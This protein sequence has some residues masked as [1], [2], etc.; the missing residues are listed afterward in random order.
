MTITGQRYDGYLLP[1][2][3]E[4]QF[5]DECPFAV[6]VDGDHRDVPIV[7]ES[8]E[9]MIAYV[10]TANLT[11]RSKGRGGTVFWN[12]SMTAA[13]YLDRLHPLERAPTRYATAFECLVTNV[14]THWILPSDIFQLRGFGVVDDAGVPLPK[15]TARWIEWRRREDAPLVAAG[16]HPAPAPVIQA[17]LAAKRDH[18]TLVQ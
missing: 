11:M 1:L 15:Q 4:I 6:I 10:T 7:G 5:A 17:F 12:A 9:D 14:F 8:I 18:L 16:I 3:V 2:R 13:P